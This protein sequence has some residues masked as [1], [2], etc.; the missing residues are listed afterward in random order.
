MP[1]S[2]QTVVNAVNG[3]NEPNL[4]TIDSDYAVGN[5]YIEDGGNDIYDDGNY[6]QVP[7]LSTNYLEYKDNCAQGTVNG[8]QYSMDMNNSGF[9]VTVFSLYNHN[10]I[11]IYGETG[12]DGDGTV[13][14]GSYESNGWK[15]FWKTVTDGYS[16]TDE[17]DP[18]INH[19]WVT[20]APSA[21]H[22]VP[23]PSDTDDDQD[24]LDSVNGYTVVYL[25]WATHPGSVSSD[26]VMQQLV[27]SVASI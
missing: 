22:M 14:T 13:G 23:F 3:V 9:S 20:N 24:I 10:A 4:F 1:V 15:G 17:E 11:S 25:M 2:C 6:I 21:S 5:N 26:T 7:A 27:T 8:Q 16:V 12:A 19:L 18:G